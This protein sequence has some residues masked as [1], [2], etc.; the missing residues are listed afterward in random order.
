MRDFDSKWDFGGFLA[1]INDRFLLCHNFPQTM[2]YNLFQDRSAGMK[3]L[4][5]KHF[6]LE[7]KER[8]SK[9]L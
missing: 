1:L 9:G 2:Q 6:A 7:C 3:T 8:I 5:T 4:F